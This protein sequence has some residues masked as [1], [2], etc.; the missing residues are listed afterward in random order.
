MSVVINRK[1]VAY[2]GRAFTVFT[3]NITLPNGK[4]T[5]LDVLKHPGA[6]AIVAMDDPETVVLIRQYRHAIESHIWEIPAGTLDPG[7]SPLSCAKRELAEETGFSA[8]TWEKLG[9]IVPVPGYSNERI[10]L[11]LASDLDAG[12]QA[13]DEGEWLEV[14]RVAVSD[15]LE[16]IRTGEIQ[17][18]KTIAGLFMARRAMGRQKA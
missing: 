15:A 18:G 3:E 9:E 2:R 5:E 7:E 8:A 17:D 14:H 4:T 12:A 16:M 13:L 10:H 1:Q 6:A 11:Y